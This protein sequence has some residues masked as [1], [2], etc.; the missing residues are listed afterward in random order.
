MRKNSTLKIVKN[1]VFYCIFWYLFAIF[2]S[3]MHWWK[4]FQF[5]IIMTSHD[6]LIQTILIRYRNRIVYI[7]NN[8]NISFTIF[9]RCKCFPGFHTTSGSAGNYSLCV[10]QKLTCV[11]EFMNRMGQFD[12]VDFHGT[13]IKCRSNCEDQ[14]NELFVTSSAYPNKCVFTERHE[15][16]LLLMRLLGK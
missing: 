9:Q 7:P 5:V 1:W 4:H 16:C 2:H 11:N 8:I 6:K 13:Q 14:S 12:H 15:F 3:G 10:G